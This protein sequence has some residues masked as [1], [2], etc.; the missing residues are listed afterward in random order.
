[1]GAKKYPRPGFDP[2]AGSKMKNS[3]Y[4]A[5]ALASALILLP[6]RSAL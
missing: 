4:T 1:M 3:R 5:A 6:I 2:T